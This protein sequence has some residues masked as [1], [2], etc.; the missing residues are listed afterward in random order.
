MRFGLWLRACTSACVRVRTRRLA[1]SLV[2]ASGGCCSDTTDRAFQPAEAGCHTNRMALASWAR[3]QCGLQ[4]RS[5]WVGGRPHCR[6]SPRRRSEQWRAAASSSGEPEPPATR[7]NEADA[8]RLLGL[9]N[10]PNAS[11]DEVR[12]PIAS[13]SRALTWHIT[14]VRSA[15]QHAADVFQGIA[16][17]RPRF[18][19]TGAS[20]EHAFDAL[21]GAI[22]AHQWSAPSSWGA[23]L[24]GCGREEPFVGASSWR[25]GQSER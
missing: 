2:P 12:G 3:A 8:L 10:N 23:V 9:S 21:L 13:V 22:L 5:H 14:A 24:A 7:I 4:S 17:R 1:F 20:P 16:R 11:F 25:Y 19:T 15:S 18:S 6:A